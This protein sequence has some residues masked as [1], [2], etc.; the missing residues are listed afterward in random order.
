MLVGEVT[1][2]PPVPPIEMMAFWAAVVVCSVPRDEL[3][4]ACVST[5]AA[6][7]VPVLF[8]VTSSAYWLVPTWSAVAVTPV[9]ASLM[10]ATTEA[11]EPSPTE[12]FWAV[13]VPTLNPPEMAAVIVPPSPESSVT[14]VVP[15]PAMSLTV[16]VVPSTSI[17]PSV[18]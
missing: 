11:S 17:W 3:E 2:K 7:A 6:P 8:D 10:P 18:P 4:K 14:C 12:T 16:V 13:M 1:W 5:V 15:V 9:S